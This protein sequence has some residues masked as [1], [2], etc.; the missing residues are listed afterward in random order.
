MKN[1]YKHFAVAMSAVLLLTGVTFPSAPKAEAAA[2]VKLSSKKLTVQVG[3][4]KTLKLKNNKKKTKWQIVSGKGKIKLKKK[5][6]NSVKI[7][8]KKAGTAKVRVKVGKKKYTCKVTVQAATSGGGN[9]GNHTVNTPPKKTPEPNY[10]A[11]SIKPVITR[12]EQ[13]ELAQNVDLD[14]VILPDNAGVLMRV[15]NNNDELLHCVKIGYELYVAGVIISSGAGEVYELPAGETRYEYNYLF[16]E[17]TVPIDSEFYSITVDQSYE[18]TDVSGYLNCYDE[19]DKDKGKIICTVEN[20]YESGIDKVPVLIIYYD[21]YGNVVDVSKDFVPGGIARGDTQ[22][23][24]INIP[25]L[26]Q[27]DNG[28][29]YVDYDYYEVYVNA[30]KI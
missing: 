30:Y 14:V 21:Q 5:K 11:P 28:Y 18:Y 6:K 13:D 17:S 12:D 29:I 19:E 26:G 7:E 10:P 27:D 2:K 23:V 9:T 25:S 16:A 4:T 22:S 3:K 8:G 15:T 20:T 24:E 1:Y